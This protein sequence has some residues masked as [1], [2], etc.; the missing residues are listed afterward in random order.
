MTQG[1]YKEIDLAK[2]VAAIMVVAIHAQPF[3]GL[4]E[5]MLI[6][7]W[8]RLAVPFFFIASA[9]FFFKKPAGQQHI[10]HYVKR[11]A[12]L[13]LFWF[14]VE[15]PITVLHFYIEPQRSIGQSTLA[16]LQGLLWGS[17][18]SGSWFIT[19][20]M[21]CI[22]LVWLLGRRLSSATLLLAGCALYAVVVGSTYYYT[23]LP[24]D[25]RSWVDACHAWSFK[26]ELSWASAFVFCVAGR[27]MAEK[28]AQVKA[29]G[30]RKMLWAWLFALTV[31]AGEVLTM[32]FVARPQST[33]VYFALLPFAILSFMLVLNLR[34]PWKFDYLRLRRYSTLFYFSHFIF[35]FILVL[36]NKHLL[37]VNPL[38]KYGLVLLLCWLLATTMLTLSQRRGFRWLKYG[39]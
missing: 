38:L 21:E 6:D 23:V 26:P 28:E 13:Y 9:F 37:P 34:C 5:A 24:P 3:S 35:V 22:P 32:F 7:V 20:L 16:L 15:L 2:M 30:S 19:A 12:L 31:A 14:V 18:F 8:A 29:I 25:W 39:F 36:V 33:D 11:L 10:G 17:T 27:L 1:E 4:T